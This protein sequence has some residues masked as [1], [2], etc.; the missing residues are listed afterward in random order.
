[1]MAVKTALDQDLIGQPFALRICHHHG[2]I[3]VF[4]PRDWYRAPQEGGPE[5]SLG[6]YGIDLALY[7]M[8]QDVETVYAQYGNFTSPDS[9]FMDCGRIEMQMA[10]NRMAAFDMY[11]CNR[12][13]YPAWQLEI[14]GPKGMISIHR[15]EEDARKTVVS[16]D[17]A[18]GHKL[19]PLPTVTPGWEMFWVDD[20]LHRR[21]PAI[22]AM[23]AKRITQIALAA[24]DAARD[25]A[26]VVV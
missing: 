17:S 1:M 6:W 9:P 22:S 8:Q 24:R 25:H 14:V 3:D 10:Q 16:L 15:V 13:P 23:D 21:K 12:F 20:F 7:L 18:A 26:T 19:L 11:F 4:R 5:L 2:V